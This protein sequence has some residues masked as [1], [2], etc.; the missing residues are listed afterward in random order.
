MTTGNCTALS[1]DATAL[2]RATKKIQ[3]LLVSLPGKNV[4]FWWLVSRTKYK[5]LFLYCLLVKGADL[6]PDGVKLK[7]L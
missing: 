3:T 2:T 7:A 6:R 5:S 1:S 4:L